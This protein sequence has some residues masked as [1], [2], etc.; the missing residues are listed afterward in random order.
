MV[1]LGQLH[2]HTCVLREEGVA[3]QVLDLI[4]GKEAAVRQGTDTLAE[5]GP[6]T[7]PAPPGK[8]SD[9]TT[10]WAFLPPRAAQNSTSAFPNS[11]GKRKNLLLE[12]I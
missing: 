12:H 10:H 1:L 3:E 8:S 9:H 7:C 11:Q 2:P 5:R 4:P 6:C